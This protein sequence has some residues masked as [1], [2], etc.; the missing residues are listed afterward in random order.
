MNFDF[1]PIPKRLNRKPLSA[2]LN[3]D[4]ISLSI[5]RIIPTFHDHFESTLI[6]L[7]IMTLEDRFIVEKLRH[8]RTSD[9]EQAFLRLEESLQMELNEVRLTLD[10]KQAGIQMLITLILMNHRCKEDLKRSSLVIRLRDQNV[11]RTI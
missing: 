11:T 3:G 1:Q 6:N 4:K 5:Q 7:L 9:H 2:S 10:H 8:T